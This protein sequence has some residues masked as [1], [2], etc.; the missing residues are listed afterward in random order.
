MEELNGKLKNVLTHNATKWS[1]IITLLV[2][3]GSGYV[4]TRTHADSTSTNVDSLGVELMHVIADVAENKSNIIARRSAD[5]S[6]NVSLGSLAAGQDRLG[7]K[8]DELAKAITATN[9]DVN[10]RFDRFMDYILEK[11]HDSSFHRGG[12]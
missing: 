3:I 9:D 7:E 2:A 1:A 6:Q 8:I 10:D 12:G 5:S 4:E 11:E